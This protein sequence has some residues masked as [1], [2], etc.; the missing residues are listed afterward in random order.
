MVLAYSLLAGTCMVTAA[1]H[2]HAKMLKNIMRS[3]MSF[4]DTT[5]SGRILNR[6]SS[7]VDVI[8]NTLPGTLRVAL[9]QVFIVLSTL[10]V[11]SYST[12]I[13]MTVIIPLGFLY[14]LV[15]VS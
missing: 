15:Q 11:I 9:T 14:Y 4:F 5:P 6:F 1:G 3:P 12:P 13:F 10:I 2:L 7:D 8:D